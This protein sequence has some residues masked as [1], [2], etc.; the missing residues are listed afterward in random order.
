VNK[1]PASEKG[2]VNKPLM[3]VALTTFKMAFKYG[4]LIAAPKCKNIIYPLTWVI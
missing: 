4:R 3:T 1:Y 2:W